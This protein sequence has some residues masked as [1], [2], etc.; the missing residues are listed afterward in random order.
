MEHPDGITPAKVT[1]ELGIDSKEAGTYL[2]H[3]V[4]AGRLIKPRRGL[5]AP[6]AVPLPLNHVESVETESRPSQIPHF[7]HNPTGTAA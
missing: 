6:N 3:L 4:D 2:G 7:P 1:A 5:Y